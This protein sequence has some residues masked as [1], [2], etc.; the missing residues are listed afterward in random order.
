MLFRSIDLNNPNNYASHSAPVHFPR[1]WNAPWF[2]WVQYDGSIMQ[3]MVRNAGE[4]L[5]DH[6]QL[7]AARHRDEGR[8]DARLA[9]PLGHRVPA[10]LRA[11]PR[12]GLR[13]H[14]CD[15]AD[16]CAVQ[17]LQED[18]CSQTQCPMVQISSPLMGPL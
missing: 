1:I 17:C 3:P 8:L 11:A 6:R 2:S 4:A 10:E 5:G 13:P 12:A 18:P 7:E 16:A 14:I 9:Q 15:R